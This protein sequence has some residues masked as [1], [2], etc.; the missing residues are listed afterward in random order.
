MGI[1]I[2]P[3]ERILFYTSRVVVWDIASCYVVTPREMLAQFHVDG[4]LP[5]IVID[6]VTQNSAYTVKRAN[7]KFILPSVNLSND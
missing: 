4:D 5:V 6:V 1:I 7:L 2:L 3:L